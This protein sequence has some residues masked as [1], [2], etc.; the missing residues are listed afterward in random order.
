MQSGERERAGSSKL[1]D[2]NSYKSA[3]RK[4][5]NERVG[6]GPVLATV[7]GGLGNGWQRSGRDGVG[8]VAAKLGGSGVVG[9]WTAW[10]R[11]GG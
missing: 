11:D 3:D 5:K 10:G 1:K 4:N 8:M 6:L 9:A 2:E 7:G